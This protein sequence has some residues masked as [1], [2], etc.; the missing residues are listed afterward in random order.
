MNIGDK[1]KMNNLR[2]M[3]ET[4]GVA[5]EVVLLIQLVQQAQQQIQQQ[6]Q[7]QTQQQVLLILLVLLIQAR[8]IIMAVMTQ[9]ELFI[10]HGMNLNTKLLIQ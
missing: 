5:Q 1:M 7:Q 8:Q 6:A 9:E 10:P 4:Q 2:M 3:V